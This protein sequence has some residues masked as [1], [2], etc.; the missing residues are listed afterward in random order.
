MLPPAPV[1]R[2]Q[3][4]ARRR[5]PAERGHANRQCL[6]EIAVGALGVPRVQPDDLPGMHVS[7]DRDLSRRGIGADEPAHEEVAL[8][9]L[10]L[11]RV[12]DDPDQ[13]AALDE[14]EILRR[15]LLD[16]LA[17]LLQRRLAGQFADHVTLAGGDRQLGPDRRGAL[18]DHRQHLDAVQS[19]AD[20]TVVDD[21]V[22]DEQDRLVVDRPPRGE[23]SEQRQHRRRLAQEPQDRVGRER[24]R[25]GEQDRSAGAVEVRHPRQRPGARLELLD[26][27]VER[28]R[29]P[30]PEARRP[31]GHRRPLLDLAPVTDHAA[32]AAPDQLLRREHLMDRL[33]RRLGHREHIAAHEQHDQIAGRAVELRGRQ[34]RRFQRRDARVERGGQTRFR[35]GPTWP[36]TILRD[37]RHRAAFAAAIL[38]RRCR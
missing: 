7:G 19:H 14:L 34:R 31:H 37:P 36:A 33:E 38:G 5:A 2:E 6:A 11:V 15:Q 1:A 35:C 26:G 12:D 23:T 13:Q 29:G 9:V 3:Q 17:Q 20:R 4:R 25:I 28:G 32:R 27:G 21:L 10:G 8:E 30:V 18:R 22:A 24:H 16:R